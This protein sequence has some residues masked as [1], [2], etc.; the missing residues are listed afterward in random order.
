MV[1]EGLLGVEQAKSYKMKNLEG[2]LKK[3]DLMNQKIFEKFLS[4]EKQNAEHA[5]K[6]LE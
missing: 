2:E 6:F 1:S 5:D 4:V 3:V